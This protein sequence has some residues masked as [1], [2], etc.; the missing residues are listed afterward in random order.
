[1]TQR[2]FVV[3]IPAPFQNVDF[4]TILLSPD[5]GVRERE[6]MTDFYRGEKLSFDLSE[7]VGLSVENTTVSVE[8]KSKSK[9]TA[10]YSTEHQALQEKKAIDEAHKAWEG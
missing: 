1:M 7:F 8:L 9:L 5:F 4:T 3:D 6:T 10:F 2:I